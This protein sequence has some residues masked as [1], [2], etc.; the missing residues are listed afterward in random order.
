[1]T[2]RTRRIDPSSSATVA[3]TPATPPSNHATRH[4]A[5]AN[6][7]DH[8]ATR[9]SV[10]DHTDDGNALLDALGTTIPPELLV[11]ALTHRSFAHEHEGALHYERLEFLGDAVLELVATET[12]FTTHPDKSEGDLAKMRAKAVSEDSLAHIATEKLHVSPYILLGNGERRAGGA[13]KSSILCD[14]VEALIGATF[15]TH[16]IEEARRV[17]HHLIDDTLAEVATEGPAL[18]WKTS[19]TVK[20]N[21]MGLGEPR[22]DTITDGPMSA[23][24]FTANVMLGTNDDIVGTGTGS[25]KR[26]AQLAAAEDAWHRLDTSK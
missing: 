17:V 18:D 5:V 13:E 1:M 8:A 9:T 14:I 15:V 3:S 24:V 12:L 16:G 21:S 23:P 11:Q 2:A 20:A 4:D 19:L 26:K 22:Y 25:S 7:S 6:A 10:G